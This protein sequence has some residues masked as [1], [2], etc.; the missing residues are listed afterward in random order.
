[1]WGLPRAVVTEHGCMAL[2]DAC[3]DFEMQTYQTATW[4]L[5]LLAFGGAGLALIAV[6]PWVSVSR[7]TLVLAPSLLAA[8]A[9]VVSVQRTMRE[10]QRVQRAMAD[11]LATVAHEESEA[12]KELLALHDSQ[13]DWTRL[14]EQQDRARRH[15]MTARGRRR[16]S[17]SPSSP[18]GRVDGCA[19]SRRA[20]TSPPP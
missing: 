1:M 17:P 10:N 20:R 14:L 11:A 12:R 15:A 18:S 9:R 16:R 6:T 4:R 2:G 19:R 3:C 7:A 8:I 5:S 13:R